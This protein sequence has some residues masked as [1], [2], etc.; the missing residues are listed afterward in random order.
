MMRVLVWAWKSSIPSIVRMPCATLAWH[1][2]FL[3]RQELENLRIEESRESPTI[4][5]IVP[6]TPEFLRSYPKRSVMVLTHVFIAFILSI[7]W[8]VFLT[9]FRS[10]LD[11]SES[12]PFVRSIQADLKNQFRRQ[13]NGSEKK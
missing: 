10:V 11:S 4:E 13:K 5:I 8:L 9:W 2:S 12:G 6:P 7:V 3:L 1:E